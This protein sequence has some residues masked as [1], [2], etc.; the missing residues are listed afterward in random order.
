MPDAEI[1]PEEK[2]TT[3]NGVTIRPARMAEAETLARLMS[4]AISWGRLS[5]LGSGFVTLLH[6]HMIGSRHSVCYVAEHWRR[7]SRLLCVEQRYGEILS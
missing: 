4:E 2:A 5:E 6:R 1:R 7:D 3:L